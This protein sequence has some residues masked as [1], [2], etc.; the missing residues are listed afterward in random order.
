MDSVGWGKTRVQLQCLQRQ[1]PGL[2]APLIRR[3]KIVVTESREAIGQTCISR[4]IT[5]ILGN[6]FL[7][8]LDT[9]GKPFSAAPVPMIA[10]LQ[11]GFVC[12]RINGSRLRQLRLLLRR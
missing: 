1:L 6:G 7:E 8:V 4:G 3:D 10:A 12:L 9:F 5:C 2:S 11:V